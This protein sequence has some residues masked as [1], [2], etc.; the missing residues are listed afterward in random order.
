MNVVRSNFSSALLSIEA[1]VK[2]SAFIA[3][4]TEF[5]GL[6]TNESDNR[7][8]FDTIES[9]YAK[10][11]R[12]AH[13]FTICQFGMSVFISDPEMK[14]YT[15]H[16][17]NFYLFPK[18]FQH[19]YNPR[20]LIQCANIEFLCEHSFDFNKWFY[21]GISFCN[22]QEEAKLTTEVVSK[23]EKEDIVGFRRLFQLLVESKKPLLGHN[24]LLDL[25]YM[26]DCF[27][28][29]LPNF[30]ATLHL[31]FP[32]IIDT[33]NISRAIRTKMDKYINKTSLD[34]LYASLSNEEYAKSV[35]YAP[36][37]VHSPDSSRYGETKCF[38]EAAYD[39]YCVGYV[40][41]KMAHFLAISNMSHP[42]PV[43]FKQYLKTIE[44][45]SNRINLV[46][47]PIN[48]IVRSHRN[49]YMYRDFKHVHA[50]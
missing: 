33:K 40:F 4:D 14:H 45:Y 37:V 50:F 3:I 24:M 23:E 42:R 47:G 10:L 1:L 5:T 46:H 38:H 27:H 28:E 17:F 6:S 32:V 35:I 19:I 20:F 49:T 48:Y 36:D 41:L 22:R 39:A 15:A 2:E 11:R 34:E 12:T 31:L 43:H 44:P 25:A 30:K 29:P 16:S 13:S 9:R 26:F 8:L 18:T 7:S 21:E